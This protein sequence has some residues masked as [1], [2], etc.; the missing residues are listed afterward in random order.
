MF[1]T[2]T[3]E[4]TKDALRRKEIHTVDRL[5]TWPYYYLNAVCLNITQQLSEPKN[6]KYS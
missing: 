2:L 3:Q 4:T 5:Q 6:H 1:Q